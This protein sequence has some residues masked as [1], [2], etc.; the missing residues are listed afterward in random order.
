MRWGA[1]GIITNDCKTF[2]LKKLKMTIVRR[3]RIAP[4]GGGIGKYGAGH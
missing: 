1:S 3:R 4:E 2:G